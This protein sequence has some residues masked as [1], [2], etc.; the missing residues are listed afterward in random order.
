MIPVKIICHSLCEEKPTCVGFNF[1]NKATN[2]ENCQLT[3]V[4]KRRNT[5]QRG[6]WTLLNDIEAVRLLFEILI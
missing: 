6:D 5:A 3:N 4:T 2:D 1:R